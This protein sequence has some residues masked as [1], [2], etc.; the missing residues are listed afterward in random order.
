MRRGSRNHRTSIETPE[1]RG[2][3]PAAVR[4]VEP[5]PSQATVTLA[6]SWWSC[7]RSG[8]GSAPRRSG[9]APAAARSPRRGAEC[10]VGTDL[11]RR[12]RPADHAA[13]PA[14]PPPTTRQV[15]R[16]VCHALK[17]PRPAPDGQGRSDRGRW[18]TSVRG[19]ASGL[20]RRNAGSSTPPGAAR[21]LRR[22]SCAEP[23]RWIPVRVVTSCGEGGIRAE[24]GIWRWAPVDSVRSVTGVD[25]IADGIPPAGSTPRGHL[26]PGCPRH[27]P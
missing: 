23:D 21:G 18:I 10:A 4:T 13:C 3:D 16:P 9:R 27:R 17:T 15:V 1:Q 25:S 22:G 6:R 7:H 2:I 20:P 26:R 11:S 5:R 12:P 19:G 24:R 8:R 14:G